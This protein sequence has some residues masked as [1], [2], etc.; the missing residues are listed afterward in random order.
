MSTTNLPV[1]VTPYTPDPCRSTYVAAELLADA[2]QGDVSLADRN[3]ALA[4]SNAYRR[5]IAD[6]VAVVLERRSKLRSFQL[7]EQKTLHLAAADMLK[8]CSPY[9][10]AL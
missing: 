7:S 9:E 1:Q 3:T 2:E 5:G 8:L 4:A 10:L 6:A